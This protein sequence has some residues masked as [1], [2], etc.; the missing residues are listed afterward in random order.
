SSVREYLASEAMAGLGIPTT[1]A[2]ALVVSD[3]PVYR[4]TIETAAI[5]TRVSPTFIRFGS[6]EQWMGDPDKLRVLTDHVLEHYYPELRHTAGGEPDTW[7]N[8]VLRMLREVVRRTAELVAGWQTVGFCHGVMN[9]DNMSIVGLTMDYGPYG[10]MDGFQANHICNHSDT[11]GRY[12]WNVQPAVAHWN[13]YRLGGVFLGVGLTEEA[14]RAALSGYERDFLDAYQAKLC[15]KFGLSAWEEGDE[16]LVDS[17]WRLL[18]GPR[19]DF[20]LSFRHLVTAMRDPAPFLHLFTDPEPAKEWLGRYRQRLGRQSVSND[21]RESSM[22]RA[23]PLYVLRNHLAQGA[24]DAAQK[25]DAGEINTLL[26]LLRDPY[27]E[28]PGR[29]HYAQQA[30]EWAERLEVSCSS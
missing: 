25:G 17:W 23:N 12:A 29:E 13:L 27:T 26:E 14:L 18:H 21:E 20:T 7:E 15:R 28:R 10:F 6:F 3:D 30:P 4:E 24:I 8:A 22:L 11:Q 19:A 2:L 9:T 5:V 16:E 1:R